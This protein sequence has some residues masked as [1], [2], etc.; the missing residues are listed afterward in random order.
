MYRFTCSFNSTEKFSCRFGEGLERISALF[1][2]EHWR[3]RWRDATCDAGEGCL[4]GGRP[5]AGISDSWREAVNKGIVLPQVTGAGRRRDPAILRR[6]EQHLHLLRELCGLE[7]RKELNCLSLWQRG[8]K[9]TPKQSN[10]Q[11]TQC[12]IKVFMF[13]NYSRIHV[14]Q[15]PAWPHR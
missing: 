10:N 12:V 1:V 11:R 5:P 3:K 9:I 4:R 8:K 7:N 15:H 2:D 6:R 13:L 14:E